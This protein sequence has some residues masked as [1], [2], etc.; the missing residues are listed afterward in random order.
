MKNN[1]TRSQIL[2]VYIGTQCLILKIQIELIKTR[3]DIKQFTSNY[4]YILHEVA[5]DSN[6]YGD[7]KNISYLELTE[8]FARRSFRKKSKYLKLILINI[9][10]NILTTGFNM[11]CKI[12]DITLKKFCIKNHSV[13]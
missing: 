5:L 11:F 10:T 13:E 3:I 6:L 4:N 2:N 9:L 1:L 8:W 12:K 7:Q